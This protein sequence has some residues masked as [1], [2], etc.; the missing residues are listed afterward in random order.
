MESTLTGLVLGGRKTHDTQPSKTSADLKKR[1]LLG[2]NIRSLEGMIL[3][4]SF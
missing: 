4:M 3:S 2:C 1:I